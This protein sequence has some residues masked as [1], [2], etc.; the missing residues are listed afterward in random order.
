MSMR[1]SLGALAKR[2]RDRLLLVLPVEP[3]RDRVIEAED[4]PRKASAWHETRRDTLEE[5]TFVVPRRQVQEPR[6]GR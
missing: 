4:V 1:L 2:V 3:P 6:N 5:A